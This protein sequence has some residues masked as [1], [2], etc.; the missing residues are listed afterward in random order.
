M[1]KEEDTDDDKCIIQKPSSV[2]EAFNTMLGFIPISHP[3][4][5]DKLYD[6][7]LLPIEYLDKSGACFVSASVSDDLELTKSKSDAL[8]M[9]ECLCEPSHD[10]GR[11]II[12]EMAGIYTTNP[13]FLEETQQVIQRMSVY[14]LDRKMS[15]C[16][17]VSLSQ[18]MAVRFKE[19]WAEIK[20]DKEFLE[21]H[22][23]MEYLFLDD[24]NHSLPFLN[25]YSAMNLLSPMYSLAL[26]L[27][28]LLMPFVLL[29]IWRV[30]I[31]FDV[32][33]KTLKDVSK[34]H[35]IGRLMNIKEMNFENALYALFIGGMFVM[36][37]YNQIIYVIKYTATIKRMNDNLV[38]MRDY[39]DCVIGSMDTFNKIMA[40]LA[41]YSDFC[42]D[43]HSHKL[44]LSELKDML[45]TQ[46]TPHSW[47]IHKMGELGYMFY[48]YYQ[49]HTSMDYEASL[50]YSVGF[51]GYIDLLRGL[52]HG[53]SKRFL[54]KATILGPDAE[55]ASK[56]NGQYYPPHKNSY[57]VKNNV[58][59]STNLIITGVNA[60]GKTTAL[61]TTALNIIFTQQTG[62]GFYD[63]AQLK[64]FRH[65]HSYLN[66]PDTSGRDSLFQAESRRCKEILDKIGDA[67]DDERHFVLFDELYSGTN[68]KEAVKSAHSLLKYLSK[69]TNVR[70]ALTTHY[71]KVCRKF[72]NSGVIKNYKM[73]VEKTEPGSFIYKYKMKRGISTLEGGIAILKSMD[74]PEEILQTISR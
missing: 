71:V 40:G 35:F 66:I 9:Y 47:S 68:P 7:F 61:K 33:L 10:F 55:D 22:S 3:Q 54:G 17:N 72:K 19:V 27:V 69:R 42:Q 62:V 48:C 43:V 30:P 63:E 18:D 13:G 39:L 26:P 15:K 41:F 24:L 25:V 11:L 29:Q 56:F 44:V 6:G 28:I 58:D 21:K 20:E 4:I 67:A 57:Y 64:P 45:Q 34:T 70:F 51:A 5:S 49:L 59:L 52:E 53:L 31:T 73:I 23:Y 60:S 1:T 65:V 2:I 32:Y 12:P 38:F 74:Y 50:R 36:Q 14:E 46:I 37:T 8:S 16:K